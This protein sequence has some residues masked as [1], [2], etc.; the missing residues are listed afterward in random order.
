MSMSDPIADMLT[1]VRNAQLRHKNKVIVQATKIKLAI[2]GVLREEGYIN[3]YRLET[4][5]NHQQL[6][7]E[8]KYYQGKPVV[9]EVCRVSRPGLRVYR[10]KNSLP[11]V[12]GGVGVAVVSTSKGVMSDAKAR[13]LGQGGEILCY[14][15]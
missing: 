10:G 4:I 2:A 9:R 5:D 6:V 1:R 8:L 11:Q 3:N 15:S 14:V 12:S 13:S 7:I